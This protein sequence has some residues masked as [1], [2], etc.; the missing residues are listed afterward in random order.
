MF[1]RLRRLGIIEDESGGVLIDFRQCNV[2]FRL[3]LDRLDHLFAGA[4]ADLRHALGAL[5][6]MRL[7]EVG[8][9]LAHDIIDETVLG[10]DDERYDL[11]PFARE[12]RQ[13]FRLGE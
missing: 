6:A 12:R 3:D 8:I 10:I 11:G 9:D 1:E 5:I 13:R 7:K 4:A 2:G